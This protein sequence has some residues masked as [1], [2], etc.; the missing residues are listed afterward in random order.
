MSKEPVLETYFT[1]KDYKCCVLFQ[2]LGYRCGYVLVP[3]WHSQYE[4]N[5]DDIPIR[6]HGGLTYSSHDLMGQTSPSW[7]IGFD[8]AHTGDMPDRESQMKYFGDN[9]QD[10]FF[11]MLNFMSGNDTGFG[12]VKN[13]DFC[14]EECKNIVDQLREMEQYD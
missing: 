4:K 2:A 9:E 11:N 6:C 12:T 8:C 13:L 3:Y 14:I 1:Y 10:D 5:F 7:W